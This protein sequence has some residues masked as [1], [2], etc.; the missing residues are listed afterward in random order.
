MVEIY[1]TNQTLF[2]TVVLIIIVVDYK[3]LVN[4]IRPW[5]DSRHGRY[6]VNLYVYKF[7]IIISKN[8]PLTKVLFG[9]IVEVIRRNYSSH[10]NLYD[11]GPC[12]VSHPVTDLNYDTSTN[13]NPRPS[14]F[15]DPEVHQY[16][17]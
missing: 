15:P 10:S 8:L 6:W 16:L 7:V 14:P 12:P 11:L 5:S 17:L 4:D 3:K 2:L 13:Y 9:L 1:C